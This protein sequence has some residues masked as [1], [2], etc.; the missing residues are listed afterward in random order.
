MTGMVEFPGSMKVDPGRGVCAPGDSADALNE[1]CFCVAVDPSVLRAEIEELL[2]A[3]GVSSSMAQTHPHLF[4][5]LPVYVPPLAIAQIAAV[6]EALDAVAALPA[7]R[8]AVMAW[9]PAIARMDPG[10]P[11]GLL[12]QR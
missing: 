4:A 8:E 9:A 12:G 11:G 6:V 10:S 5:S 1:R 3:R 7:Y 2:V